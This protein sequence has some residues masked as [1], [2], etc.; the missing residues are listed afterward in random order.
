ME[1]HKCDEFILNKMHAGDI[2][3]R[4]KRL[5]KILGAYKEDLAT[6]DNSQ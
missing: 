6:I 1:G 4:D 5:T 3:F 2:N